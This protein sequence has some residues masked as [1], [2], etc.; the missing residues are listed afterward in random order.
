MAANDDVENIPESSA[1][2]VHNDD[3]VEVVGENSELINN[4]ESSSRDSNNSNEDGV[5]VNTDNNGSGGDS[6]GVVVSED[7]GREDMFMDAPEDL[8]P[9]GR[10]SSATFTEAQGSTDGE[11]DSGHV[12]HARFHGLD[13]EMQNDYMVDEME[14]LRA[15]LDKTLNEKESILKEHKDE[16]EMAAKGIANLRDQMRDFSNK[17]LSRH[18]SQPGSHNHFHADVDQ[19]QLHEMVHECAMFLRSVVEE[20]QDLNTESTALLVSQDI[21]NSYLNSVQNESAEVQ[22]QKDQYIDDVTNRMLNSFSSLVYV[23]DLS[24]NSSTGKIAHIEKS[25][26]SLIENY[27]WFL[28]QS[29]QLRQYL[30]ERR[31]DLTGQTDYGVIF[32]AAND[33]LLAFTKKEMDFAERLSHF[34]KENSEVKEQLEKHKAIA[35]AANAELERLK[36]EIDQER[37]R[38]SNTKEKL[39]LAVTKGKALVQ[40]RDTLKQALAHK[41]SEVESCLTELKEKS[42]AL[43]A[44]ELIKEE[45]IKSQI[46]GAALQ[47]VIVQ[48]DLLL[49]KLEDILFECGVPEGLMTKDVTEKTRWLVNER[50]ALKDVSLK[51]HQLADALLSIDLPEN[52]SF[53]D[54]ESRLG[55]LTK[56]F[57]Q[58]KADIV[59][60]QDEV[61]QTAEALNQ[62][63]AEI[64]ALRDQNVMTSKTAQDEMGQLA[65]SLSTVLVEKGCVEVTLEDMSD[66]FDLITQRER[67]V[68]SEKDHVLKILL[69]AAGVTVADSQTSETA[70]LVEKCLSILKERW[71]SSPESSETNEETLQNLQ[72]LVYV[73]DQDL[74]LRDKL[75]EEESQKMKTEM[76]KLY[77]DLSKASEET[78]TLK[79]LND[80]LKRD[81]ERT[82]D[83][84]ALIREKLTLAVKKGKGLVQEREGL[85]QLIN[86]KTSEI[87]NLKLELQQRESTISNYESESSKLSTQVEGIPKLEENLLTLKDQRDQLERD[88]LDRNKLIDAVME[89]IN[90][91]GR[92]ETSRFEQPLEKLKWL[93]EYLNECEVVKEQLEQQLKNL[94]LEVDA[95]T[96]KVAE[97][98]SSIK[99]LQDALEV[100]EEK[101]SRVAEEKRELENA[102]ESTEQH[103]ERAM[104]EA[105][106]FAG[107]DLAKKALEN[108][109]ALAESDVSRLVKEREEAESSSAATEAELV[110]AK[111]EIAVLIAD[112]SEATTKVKALEDTVS[113]MDSRLSVLHDEN[114]ETEISRAKLEDDLKKFKEEAYKLEDAQTHIKTLEDELAKA[115]NDIFVLSNEKKTAEQE[116]STLSAK[117]NAC[118]EELAGTH[119]SLESKTL[120]LFD[121]LKG[122]EL[123]VEDESVI[124]CLRKCFETNYESLKEF[125]GLLRNTRCQFAEMDPEVQ[126]AS[127]DL[128]HLTKLISTNLDDILCVGAATNRVDA[129]ESNDISLYVQKM[130]ESFH[131]KNKSLTEQVGCFLSFLNESNASMLQELLFT[132][133]LVTPMV[134]K[135]KN[136]ETDYSTLE[137]KVAALEED[138]SS[139]LSACSDATQLLQLE[140]S[141]QTPELSSTPEFEGEN[142][143]VF[144]E[145]KYAIAITMLLSASKKVS[146]VCEQLHSS[147]NSLSSATEELQS[148]LT[149][150]KVAAS[151]AMKERD[152]YDKKVHELETDIATIQN[153]CSELRL[154]LENYQEIE[155][156]LRD[157]NAEISSLETALVTKEREA[158]EAH[159]WSSH[160]KN[161][162]EKANK[163][164]V[165]ME[166]L[167]AEDLGSQES[168]HIGKLFYIIDHFPELQ[169]QIDSLTRENTK[170]QTTLSAQIHETEHLKEQVQSS[171]V[172]EQELEKV[173]SKIVDMED[174][175]NRIIQKFSS[176]DIPEDQKL[177][178]VNDLVQVLEK[179]VMAAILESENWKSKALEF[180]LEAEKSINI[181]KESAKLKGEVLNMQAGVQN[182][183]AILRSDISWDRKP[184]ASSDLVQVLEDLVKTVVSEHENLK[185]KARE[186]DT[187]TWKS[188]NEQELI[189]VKDELSI[190]E[191][192]LKKII[193]TLRGDA[194]VDQRSVASRD[195]LQHLEKMIMALI[196]ETENSKSEIRELDSKLLG[197]QKIT[198]DLSLKVKSLED[199]LQSRI[200]SS[201][202]VQERAIFEAA[203]LPPTSE[204]SEIEDAGSVSKATISPAPSSTHVRTM[205]KGSSDH[206]AVN[207][208]SETSRLIDNEDAVEDK[209]HVFKSLNTSGLVPS[210]GK[211]I[212]DRVDGFCFATSDLVELESNYQ[213]RYG[214]KVVAFASRK[215]AKKLRRN[216]EQKNEEMQSIKS[217]DDTTEVDSSPSSTRDDVTDEDLSFVNSKSEISSVSNVIP[218]RGVVIQACILTSGLIAALGFTIRQISPLASEAGLPFFDCSQVSFGFEVWHLELIA[219][220]IVL[221]SISRYTLINTWSGFAE[222]S[223]SANTQVL[224]SLQTF[225]Y[226]IVAFL[227]G[228]SEELLFRGALLPL[229]GLNW[230]S[231]LAVA[232]VFGVLHLGS[233]RKISFAIWATFV[234]LAYGYATIV[235]SSIVVPMTAHALNNLIGAVIWYQTSRS[236]KQLPR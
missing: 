191:G 25:L 138:V 76:D 174:G 16:M 129:V 217:L 205:W 59:M 14:R 135:M 83:K 187:E 175:L 203:S 12:Q 144:R 56:S 3:D 32:A 177:F 101:F 168:A 45:L 192:G 124:S 88:L 136:M 233:G 29:D 117:L 98:Q 17:Q 89:S 107:A 104:G 74:V 72:S 229:F 97:A 185:S 30:T 182:V 155:I 68:L 48:K 231:A 85:K 20:V 232:A 201:D 178:D 103:L 28:Y 184:L 87:E 35:E 5:M 216:K 179:L 207:I 57:D 213:E 42:S 112:L 53:S 159:I 67:Q 222:S 65:T 199:S 130:T 134:H 172:H 43:E 228:I 210:Q 167:Q 209:G 197:S 54:L 166:A 90:S 125:E 126:T 183:I 23:G 122:L 132:T 143:P 161:L 116:L 52:F 113:Q 40:Q 92:P 7:A 31:P 34:E 171:F 114:N 118:L 51:F 208:D 63:N 111:S 188:S 160:V 13:N 190:I 41:T 2:G 230:K 152:F 212:A 47:E 102:R 145:S 108:A 6:D 36:A 147:R 21:V 181:E 44:A 119:G 142:D 71:S 70:K 105:S 38:Y 200:A 91:I 234:G 62:A 8:G 141:K 78:T 64:S 195:L 206:I 73:K 26:Y 154:K 95:L 131:V 162:L 84:S 163:I 140:L 150:A 46:S 115:K 221:I 99:S 60:L 180:E 173:K 81:L 50:D 79:E 100:A 96:F 49:E 148:S 196:T 94:M 218:S 198:S 10:D 226:P 235:T 109:L 9:D 110:K 27:N 169:D 214:T 223:E 156:H 186:L 227:P 202:S 121:H 39:S 219:G 120:G 4:Q 139:L 1:I 82:E 146:S 153:L 137:N 133:K 93:G 11:E 19:A 193:Q 151:E 149:E 61:S 66:K 194:T 86:E 215:S 165:S 80:N 189:E 224:T 176:K 24:D 157:K 37:H 164:E 22:Y 127:E 128:S 69:E 75:L 220:L 18:D 211:M 170:L 123:A 15:M 106:L 33:E 77:V 55:W 225:D 236:S 204:I 158:G 58:A